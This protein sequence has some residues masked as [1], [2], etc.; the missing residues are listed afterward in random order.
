MFS[1][2]FREVNQIEELIKQ[3]KYI[4]NYVEYFNILQDNENKEWWEYIEIVEFYEAYRGE[5]SS[6]H[7]SIVANEDEMQRGYIIVNSSGK[8][9]RKFT[10]AYPNIISVLNDYG[11]EG[12]EVI[13]VREIESKEY[14][15]GKDFS[16]IAT[17]TLKR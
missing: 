16:A 9:K 14:K 3:V 11:S 12:W 17:Y 4:K 5:V 8:E 1:D 2:E 10:E 15:N 6:P 13:S 7:A